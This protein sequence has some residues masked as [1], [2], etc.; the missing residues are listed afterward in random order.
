MKILAI[1]GSAKKGNTYSVLNT[2]K[3]ENPNIDFKI[4]ML[5][6]VNLKQCLGCYTCVK[7][8][9]DKCPL[10]DERESII[11]EMLDADGVIFASPVYVMHITAIMK[12]FF[13]RVGYNDHRPCFYGKTAMVM[14]ICAGF[15]A[16]DSNE[17]MKSMVSIFGFNVASILELKIAA[18]TEKENAYNHQKTTEAFDIFLAKIKEAKRKK[19]TPTLTQLIYY[20]VFKS[21]SELQKDMYKADYKFYKEKGDFVCEANINF[22]K[23]MF[24]DFMAGRIIKNTMKNR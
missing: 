15:G 2:I 5:K 7:I 4:L 23:K 24:A 16:K 11:K 13:E 3:E 22:F 14:S 18:K 17:Y 1:C 6:D 9:E 12:N 10:K 19:P 8:G 21:L 20:N